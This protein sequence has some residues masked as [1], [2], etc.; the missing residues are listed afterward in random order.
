[1]PAD[2]PSSLSRRDW[3]GRFSR[4][5]LTAAVLPPPCKGAADP[6]AESW[7]D[8]WMANAKAGVEGRT[9]IGP[10]RISRFKDPTY[11]LLQPITWRPNQ[12]QEKYGTVQVARGFI[13]DF[14]SIPA[15]FWSVLRPDGD[16]AYAAVIHDYL[17]WT[18]TK[19]REQ[20]DEIFRFAMEDFSV[21]PTTAKTI[22]EAV[23][24]FGRHAWDQNRDLREKGEKRVLR[25]FPDDP[26]ITWT[27]W[28]RRPDVFEQ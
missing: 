22:Y 20:S 18:Q 4:L 10:L 11:F 8:A 16:Y 7:L 14:A 3:L 5:A 27:D 17:Y 28:K 12:G 15:V 6:T 21:K 2:S 1:M 19:T 25:K 24:L 9:P 23:S 13:T 26:R